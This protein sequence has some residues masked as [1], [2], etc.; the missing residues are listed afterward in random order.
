MTKKKKTFEN[1]Y[2]EAERQDDYWIARRALDFTEGIVQ[3]MTDMK[4]TR[5]ELARSLGTSQAYIT[6]LLR[7]DVNFTLGTMVRLARALDA[8]LRLSLCMKVNTTD[9]KAPASRSRIAP[10]GHHAHRARGA[11]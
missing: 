8:E 10:A 2:K 1:L 6:K 3:V 5:A 7:G 4:V 9:L 11:S